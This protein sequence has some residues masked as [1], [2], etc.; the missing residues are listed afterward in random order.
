MCVDFRDM[1]KVCLKDDFPLPHIDVIVD[2]AASSAIYSFMDRFS[3][4]NQIIMV[5]MDKIKIAFI[6]ERG[7]YCYK[8][9]PFE[10]KNAG[11]TYQ[12]VATALFHDMIHKE[13]EVYVD[14]MM[15]KLKT[16]EGHFE[17]LDKFLARLEKY[18]LRFNSKGI[19]L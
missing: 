3:G 10:L 9:M 19:T 4:Y 7:T 11:A 12:R 13:V 1:K 16:R 5:V 6:T 18:N 14:D 15:V 17:A 2:S 8:V